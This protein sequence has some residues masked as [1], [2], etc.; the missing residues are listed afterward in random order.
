M[1]HLSHL[2][3]R[4]SD[5]TTHTSCAMNAIGLCAAYAPNSPKQKTFKHTKPSFKYCLLHR[6]QS[7]SCSLHSQNMQYARM[8]TQYS[9]LYLGY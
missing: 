7:L 2:S 5:E 3:A 6:Y 4:A 1:V 9:T 8:H